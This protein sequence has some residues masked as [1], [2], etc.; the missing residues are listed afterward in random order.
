MLRLREAEESWSLG[1][2]TAQHVLGLA[3]ITLLV[4]AVPVYVVFVSFSAAT[5]DGTGLNKK[6]SRATAE[7][8]AEQPEPSG[9]AAVE[10]RK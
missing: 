1:D 6:S 10:R 8:P 5:S 2:R 4:L 9:T 7:S 3:L